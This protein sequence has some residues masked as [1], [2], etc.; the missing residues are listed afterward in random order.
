MA[1]Y[2]LMEFI[3]WLV[4][5]Q[6][7][8]LNHALAWVLG[9]LGWRVVPAWRRYMA[10]ENI[11]DC[12]GVDET[13]AE[14]IARE[15]VYRFGRML[16]EVLKYPLITRDNFRQL[17]HFEG[18]ENLEKAYAEDKGVIMCTAHYGNW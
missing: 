1:A 9:H 6:P 10:K 18:L 12:L 8:C 7:D 5:H 4:C 15:S 2:K 11:K 17:V 14:K 16:I 3:S 13:E